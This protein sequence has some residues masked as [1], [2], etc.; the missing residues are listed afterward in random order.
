MQNGSPLLKGSSNF[1]DM[2]LKFLKYKSRKQIWWCRS[3]VIKSR[4]RA[5][6]LPVQKQ[7]LQCCS[8]CMARPCSTIRTSVR[9]AAA[10]IVPCSARLQSTLA[11]MEEK[12]KLEFKNWLL[13]MEVARCCCCCAAAGPQCSCW[14][15]VCSCWPSVQLL[16]QCA[17]Q[18]QFEPAVK[19]GCA[20]QTCSGA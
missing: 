16:A 5:A 10:V 11:G 4:V 13:A 17:A 6:P 7:I 1:S 2:Q 20:T 3:K 8:R 14:P 9:P 12:S 19:R 15:K 18:H